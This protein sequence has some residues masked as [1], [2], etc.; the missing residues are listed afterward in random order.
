MQMSRDRSCIRWRVYSSHYLPLVDDGGTTQ[1][2]TELDV[3]INRMEN[4]I[5]LPDLRMSN[6]EGFSQKITMKMKQL[7]WEESR[8]QHLRQNNLYSR[9][10]ILHEI[11]INTFMGMWPPVF[12]T[13]PLPG[14]IEQHAWQKEKMRDWI[15]LI[16]FHKQ[17]KKRVWRQFSDALPCR[18]DRH[19]Y[20][21]EK[22][23]V[24]Y[25]RFMR[26]MWRTEIALGHTA[27]HS[28]SL[29]QLP[30]PSLSMARTI[31]RARSLRSGWP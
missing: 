9:L 20:S 2:R 22:D 28:N 23:A 10:H 12:C 18:E 11:E 14:I 5:S 21:P 7:S 13:P 1:T 15:R 4:S 16:Q 6:I 17:P 26:A 29:E 25:S 24:R 8:N 19:G 31:A 27:S 30:N 3:A